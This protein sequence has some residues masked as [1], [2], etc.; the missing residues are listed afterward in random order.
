MTITELIK[1]G[2][3]YG[4]ITISDNPI[5]KEPRVVVATRMLSEVEDV[6]LKNGYDYQQYEKS[7]YIELKPSEMI[8]FLEFHSEFFTYKTREKIKEAKEELEEFYQQCKEI[9]SKLEK[10]NEY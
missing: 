10:N 4:V 1:Q 8:E 2:T 3:G 7:F 6:V 9:K 5:T